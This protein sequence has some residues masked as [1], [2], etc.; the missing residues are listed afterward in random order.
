MNPLLVNT[1]NLKFLSILLFED[2]LIQ[3]I[4]HVHF[5]FLLSLIYF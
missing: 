5:A 2:I 1:T 3:L 4:F